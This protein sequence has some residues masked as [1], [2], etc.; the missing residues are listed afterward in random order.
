MLIPHHAVVLGQAQHTDAYTVARQAAVAALQQLPVGA[1]PGWALVIC[2]GQHAPEELLRGFRAA[3]GSIPLVG[4]CAAGLITATSVSTGGHACGLLLFSA[5]LMPIALSIID[6]LDQ[7]EAAAGRQLGARLAGLPDPGPV[8]LFYDSI[9]RREPLELNVCSRLLDGLYAGLGAAAAP[10]LLGAGT[11][12]DMCFSSSY[13]F[14]GQNVRQHAALAVMLPPQLQAQIAITHGCYPASDFLEITAIDGARVL[15]LDGQPALAVAAARLGTSREALAA[16]Q[17]LLSLTLGEKHGDPFAPFD[18]RQYVNRLV[19]S[20][21]VHSDALMLFE[22]DFRRG[23][24]VQLMLYDPARMFESARQQTTALL[25]ALG[26][27]EPLFGLYID[28][29]G[30]STTFSSLYDDETAPIR[31]QVATRCPLLGFYSG[32][33]IA[34]ILGRSRPLDWTGVLALFTVH[35]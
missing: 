8:L 4:G 31:Q 34:P 22:A 32:V 15:E 2:G 27:R 5:A 11:L 1:A 23:S 14:D 35:A 7:D 25:A 3:L 13:I 30:R 24:R 20:A 28:C 33:E 29:A 19:M 12:G 21:D 6:G 17:P 10:L 16:R 26:K 18:D 9:K